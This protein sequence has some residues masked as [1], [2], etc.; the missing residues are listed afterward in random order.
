MCVIQDFETITPNLLARTI[1]TVEG[2]G[3]VVLLLSLHVRAD[4]ST[5]CASNCNARLQDFFRTA[6]DRNADG[7]L[8]LSEIHLMR[9]A[10]AH[11][12]GTPPLAASDALSFL[13]NADTMTRDGS[14]SFWEL[15]IALDSAR[16]FDCGA[17][18]AYGSANALDGQVHLSLTGVE[19][20]MRV[21]FVTKQPLADPCVMVS[22]A[23][24]GPNSSTVPAATTHY[25]V[26]K[27]AWEPTGNGGYIHSAVLRKLPPA[28]IVNYHP[29]GTTIS[30]K[31]IDFGT[32]SF[33]TA[34]STVARTKIALLGTESEA[35]H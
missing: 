33:K 23:D 9:T 17:S 28:T 21:T 16:G 31:K 5:V 7:A 15:C 14:I 19:G 1:E 3:I 24:A 20:E 18:S 32:Q 25:T 30:G 8:S 6:L 35:T 10:T 27:R 2:G 34:P 29:R 22:V 26:P 13:R 11:G 12:D 4:S